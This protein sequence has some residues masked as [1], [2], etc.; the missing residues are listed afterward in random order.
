MQALIRWLGDII[1]FYSIE[2]LSLLPPIFIHLDGYI[3]S[4]NY[5]IVVTSTFAKRECAVE[6]NEAVVDNKGQKKMFSE[7]T[8]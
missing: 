1:L 6:R 2:K 4:W 3:L 7:I 5:D 8:I